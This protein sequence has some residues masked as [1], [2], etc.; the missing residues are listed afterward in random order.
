MK[1]TWNLDGMFRG[2]TDPAYAADMEALQ[3]VVQGFTEFAGKL[4]TMDTLTGLRKGIAWE[5]KL[6]DL[7]RKLV[8]YAQLRQATNTRDAECGSR[9]GQ[10]MQYFS[11]AAGP[12]AAWKEWAAARE[13]L[14]EQVNQDP[15]LRD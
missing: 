2:F 11:A 9:L 13:D 14:M 8:I 12:E 3:S 1:D 15:L 5:E 10:A 6:L 7:G 4:D